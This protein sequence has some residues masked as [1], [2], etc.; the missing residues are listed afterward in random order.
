MKYKNLYAKMTYIGDQNVVDRDEGDNEQLLPLAEADF[1]TAGGK[2]GK[3]GEL[4][5]NGFKVPRGFVIPPYWFLEHCRR[6]FSDIASN[7][8]PAQR[9][10]AIRSEPLN[11][12]FAKRFGEA[13]SQ[14]I[15]ESVAVRS[16]STSEDSSEASF[17]GQFH[18]GL[19]KHTPEEALI[20]VRE[21]WASAWESHVE[22]YARNQGRGEIPEMAVV[23]QEL[24]Q[25]D[26][27]G[28][29][30]TCDPI[31]M[32]PQVHY[33][34]WVEGAGE[35]LVQGA[36]ISG[37]AWLEPGGER[38]RTDY[39][40]DGEKPPDALWDELVS[41][42]ERISSLWHRQ[43]IEWAWH[44]ETLW[45]LQS[46]PIAASGKED[47]VGPRPWRLPG[48]PHGGWTD[49]H[50][51]LFDLWDEYNPPAIPPL[52]YEM[53]MGSI[54]QATLDM[55]SK[56]G[57]SPRI[58]DV[59]VT[60]SKVPVAV[61]PAARGNDVTEADIEVSRIE[62][63]AIR[64]EEAKERWK[65]EVEELRSVATPQEDLDA[66]LLLH[67]LDSTARLYRDATR[68]RLL[69][70]HRWIEGEEDAKET[71]EKLI[72]E[73]GMDPESTLHSLSMGIDHETARMN[74]DLRTLAKQAEAAG[75]TTE[76]RKAFDA[77]LGRYGHFLSEGELL[78][79]A[80]EVLEQQI[81]EM[82]AAGLQDESAFKEAR[83]EAN[84]AVKRIAEGLDSEQR[85]VFEA[86][87]DDLRHW[88]TLREDTKSLQ[89]LPR[90]LFRELVLETGNRL[91]SKGVLQDPED[92]GLLTRSEIGDALDGDNIPEETIDRRKA[93]V[94]W[95]A[96]RPWLPIG[97]SGKAPSK[98]SAL[99]QGI[100]GSGGEA[101]GPARIV[102]SPK[103]FG[104]VRGGDVVVARATNPLW[105]QLFS[106]IAAIVVEHGSRLSHA[107]ITAR[108][109]GIP[110][111][112][113]VHG[114]TTVIQDEERLMVDGTNG[115]V[116]RL[117]HTPG[118][119]SADQDTP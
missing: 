50:N 90:P 84:Q 44:D 64:L 82:I 71:L 28:V 72:S 94:R 73:A 96:D 68:L 101:D 41:T 116:V 12:D 21:C 109:F 47:Y 18:T 19:D 91:A 6:A 16:S 23:V 54:W 48:R 69:Q 39:L 95:K 110:A 63:N 104:S 111:V 2:G 77:F 83:Q 81:D 85:G 61:D 117:D 76:W 52:E 102:R 11:E 8:S 70:M 51:A 10:D 67:L 24:V 97:F 57:D 36:A 56:D 53:Y 60:E 22:D 98:D 93:L 88:I 113:D 5:R 17:A 106:R 38:R 35:S 31:S 30:F 115:E 100:P 62:G 80:P 46:R 29:A 114:A 66:R 58:P 87:L 32:S 25:P 75:K 92:V 74:E 1:V 7:S 108:E 27:S 40:H 59:V 45:L 103:E 33:I 43:D 86:A 79:E 15:H 13:W 99:L 14:H 118:T 9:A 49:R 42:L 65:E 105:T 3:L 119:D 112:V 107:A 34:E 89:E 37:R 4:S 55:L 26:F 78:I 20:E